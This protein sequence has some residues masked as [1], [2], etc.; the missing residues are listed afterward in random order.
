LQLTTETAATWPMKNPAILTISV[1]HFDHSLVKNYI[2]TN[3]KKHISLIL[4]K[5]ING[6]VFALP[7]KSTEL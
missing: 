4:H 1:V 6:K 7:L 5:L 2:S 3:N